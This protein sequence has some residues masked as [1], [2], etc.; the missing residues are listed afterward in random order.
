MTDITKHDPYLSVV[1]K[2][3]EMPLYQQD[4]SPLLDDSGVHITLRFH[5]THSSVSKNFQNDVTRKHKES[6]AVGEASYQWSEMMIA[7]F[8]GWDGDIH[9]GKKKLQPNKSG[10]TELFKACPGF[11]DE[12]L[13]FVKE[14]KPQLPKPRSHWTYTQDTEDG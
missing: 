8:D 10:V 11:Y 7:L 1:E 2:P 5:S 6:G 14:Y 4:G 3:L 9:I 12:S 13:S